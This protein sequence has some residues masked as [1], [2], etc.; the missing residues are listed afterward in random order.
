MDTFHGAE[1]CEQPVYAY[2]FHVH[3]SPNPNHAAG[4]VFSPLPHLLLFDP[5]SM[6]YGLPIQSMS[7][8]LQKQGRSL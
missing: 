7:V 6:T 4:T 2:D 1:D 3:E 5:L 8:S